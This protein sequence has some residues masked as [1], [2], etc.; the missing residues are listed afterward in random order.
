MW[1]EP[2]GLRNPWPGH[3]P[4]PHHLREQLQTAE[5]NGIARFVLAGGLIVATVQLVSGPVA[6]WNARRDGATVRCVLQ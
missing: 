4:P 1:W 6:D 3:A 2:T 5:M